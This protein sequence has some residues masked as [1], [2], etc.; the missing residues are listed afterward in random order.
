MTR[1]LATSRIRLSQAAALSLLLGCSKPGVNVLLETAMNSKKEQWLTIV[2]L[3]VPSEYMWT[4][5][6]HVHT[7]YQSLSLLCG[8]GLE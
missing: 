3:T 4:N 6:R 8:R 1:L 5:I 7:L 2:E